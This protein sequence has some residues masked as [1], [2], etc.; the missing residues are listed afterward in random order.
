MSDE[1]KKPRWPWAWTG[2][3]LIAVFVLYPVSVGPACWLS[4]KYDGAKS[5]AKAVETIYEPIDWIRCKSENLDGV[6]QW[7]LRLWV[8]DP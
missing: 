2:W 8:D 4:V 1:P 5:S 7:Y 3:A 6:L